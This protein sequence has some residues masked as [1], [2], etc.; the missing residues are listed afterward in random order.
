MLFQRAE[1]RA[2]EAHHPHRTPHIPVVLILALAAIALTSCS[3]YPVYNASSHPV[4]IDE[5]DANGDFEPA[6]PD[7]D[8]NDRSDYDDPESMPVQPTIFG[9]VVEEYLDVP[10]AY[11]GSDRD[12][13]D[14]SHLVRALYRDYDGTRLP[15]STGRLFNLPRDV[16]Y[17]DLAVGDL[18]FFNFNGD[19]A[20]HV[21]VYL[22]DERFVHAS[23]SRGVI[24]STLGDPDYSA[25]YA[26]A[27]RVK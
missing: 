25:R 6:E 8:R 10:Y 22:G 18:V 2:R 12:G 16:R 13:I 23:K 20:S 14:C 26:G 24:I 5:R 9:R 19:E 4:Q 27:R 15:A 11:G 21:G 3:P 17:D 1:R 7:Y